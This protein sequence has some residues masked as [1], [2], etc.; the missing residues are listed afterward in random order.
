[1]RK[2]NS[3][4][5]SRE[6]F[7]LQGWKLC[8]LQGKK[9]YLKVR[10]PFVVQEQKLLKALNSWCYHPLWSRALALHV[11]LISLPDHIFQVNCACNWPGA[12][13]WLTS[14]QM[15]NWMSCEHYSK[16]SK[17]QAVEIVK[18]QQQNI[19]K[20]KHKLWVRGVFQ[21][22]WPKIRGYGSRESLVR[23]CNLKY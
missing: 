6:R 21:N 7:G 14:I 23:S 13:L 2:L 8:L 12:C 10:K 16:L 1:M 22:F 4:V 19:R 20:K 18:K 3:G 9:V 5:H 11:A 15:K 17:C